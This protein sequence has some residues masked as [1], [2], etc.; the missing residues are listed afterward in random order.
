MRP[1]G[2]ECKYEGFLPNYCAF[3]HLFVGSNGNNVLITYENVIKCN[4]FLLTPEFAS[5]GDS[6]ILSTCFIATVNLPA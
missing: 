3:D 4:F 6:K 1:F 5:D 2:L